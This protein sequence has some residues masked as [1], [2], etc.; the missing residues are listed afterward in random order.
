MKARMRSKSILVCVAFIL[1]ITGYLFNTLLA[2][3]PLKALDEPSYS[4]GF[5]EDVVAIQMNALGFPESTLYAPKLIHFEDNN[6]T[7]LISPHFVILA[8]NGSPWNIYA[9]FG[10]TTKG[11]DRVFLWGNVKLHQDKDLFGVEST[12]LT[13]TM[14]MFPKTSTAE[15]DQA[16][17]MIQP[18]KIINAVG[19]K[20]NF[21]ESTIELLSQS[22]GV[23]DP[24]K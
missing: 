4:D 7:R 23:Y 11:I 5:M 15:T 22:R 13:S 6:T 14:T 21:K 12:I 16:V 10:V 2:P 20:S 3:E 18:N 8:K 9:D 17:T 24:T 19:L 1:L